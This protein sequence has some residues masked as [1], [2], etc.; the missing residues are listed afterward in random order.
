VYVVANGTVYAHGEA[1]AGVATSGLLYRN[2][3]SLRSV[4]PTEALTDISRAP[5][6]V[7]APIRRAAHTGVGVTHRE[8]TVPQ[9][10][11]RT[12]DGAYYRVYLVDQRQPPGDSGWIEP[13]LVLGAPVTGL[14]AL[15]RLRDRVEITYLHATDRD[16]TGQNE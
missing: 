9:T 2:E 8:L 16:T 10:P 15:H 14:F 7:P 3:L 1:P 13:L 12:E 5:D 11:I 6:E 4:S